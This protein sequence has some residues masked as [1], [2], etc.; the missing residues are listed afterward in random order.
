MR[1]DPKQILSD[2]LRRLFSLLPKPNNFPVGTPVLSALVIKL[3]PG[4]LNTTLE[5][6]TLL[7]KQKSCSTNI[8]ISDPKFGFTALHCL[9]G[10]PI[11]LDNS[12]LG[13]TLPVVRYLLE[14]GADINSPDKDG[15]TPLHHLTQNLNKENTEGTVTLFRLLLEHGADV[16]AP[17]SQGWTPIHHLSRYL[18][19]E[20]EGGTVT[21]V[22]LLL[23]HGINV[24]GQTSEG[25]TPLHLLAID[26][27]KE[28]EKGTMALVRLL[29]EHGA[30]VTAQDRISSDC[31][32][33]TMPTSKHKTTK[34]GLH[35]TNLPDISGRRM[36]EVL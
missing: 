36:K 5:A 23:K 24:T 32:W 18:R 17:D 25:W 29:L 15:L 26:L 2:D 21:L 20:N 28:N 31:S 10:K 14:K 35:F 8:N 22:R 11:R 19:K 12:H 34:G 27:N 9:L 16:T 7:L 6:I 3:H 13:A 30:D 1:K 4:N 33:S